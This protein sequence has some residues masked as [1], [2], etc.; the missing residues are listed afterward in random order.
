MYFIYPCQG[1]FVHFPLHD[2]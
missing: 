1:N 2:V